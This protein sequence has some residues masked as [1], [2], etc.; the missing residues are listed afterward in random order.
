MNRTF[1]FFLAAI[2][3]GSM[4]FATPVTAQYSLTVESTPALHVTGNN[5]YRFYVNMVDPADKFSA[6]FG[7]DQDHLVINAPAGVYNDGFVSGWSAAGITPAFAA[8]VPSMTEDTY[9]TIGLTGPAEGSEADPSLV[10]DNDLNPTISD[11]FGNG[12]ETSLN[13]NT[14]TGGSW[15]VLNTAANAL[16]DANLRV[17]VMQI[18]TSG[19]VSGTIN[20]QVFPLGVGEDQ[21]QFNI[22]FDGAGTYGGVSGSVN[23]CGCMDSTACNY[24]PT[25]DYDDGSCA[26]IGAGECD[27]DENVLDECGVCGGD[28]SSCIGCMDVAACNYNPEAE[29]DDGSCD[30][31]CYGCVDVVACNY[32]E[33]ST[34][35]DGSCEYCD[36]C[37][38]TLLSVVYTLTVESAPAVHVDG[39]TV[40]RFHV[41]MLDPTDKFSAVFGNDQKN[42]VINTPDGIFNSPYNASWSASGLAPAFVA[43]FPDMAEDSYATIGLDG[44]AVSPQADPALTE[45]TSIATTISQYFVT[46]GT[47]LN[48]NTL[49]GGSWYVLNTAANAL[50]DEDLR[51]LVM[52]VTTE[53]T[54][55]GTLN[56]QVFPLGVGADQVQISID[57]DGVGT[58][59]TGTVANACGCTDT[60][61]TNY[62]AYADYDDDSCIYPSGCMD[63]AACNYDPLAYFDDGTCDYTTCAGCTDVTACDYDPTATISDTCLDFTSCYGCMEPEADNYDPTATIDDGNCDYY[64]CTLADACNYDSTANTDDGSCEFTS[65]V[66]CLTPTA[67][68]YDPTYLYHYEGYCIYPEEGYDCDGICLLDTD[69]DGICDMFEISGCIDSIACN[70]EPEADFDDGSCEYAEYALDCDGNCLNELNIYGVCPELEVWG[71]KYIFSCNYDPSVNMDDGSCEIDSCACPGDFNG[72]SEV[73]VSDLLDFFL[74]WGGNCY[75]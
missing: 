51:V 47:E 19:T 17:L 73:D 48:V 61:A 21:V 58:F 55:S 66:G 15:Y 65:C 2:C 63:V 45:D 27:C 41:N 32:D 59:G 54:V 8:M 49:T 43:F 9:A 56:Y 6:V 57:F 39:N 71:C 68:N 29:E 10:Q 23:A 40:Y 60:A 69:G 44:P 38:Y 36:G 3:C 75:E 11:F 13:V 52:Q 50:P 30:Y 22:D 14:L 16:P 18:T 5:V 42:L 1:N 67:C 12:A 62:D 46:G 74:L 33:A 25:A 31:S 37:D 34:T 53:G 70:F 4:I 26:F 35:D 20:Y 72:D 64:G 28:N 7:N 24:D